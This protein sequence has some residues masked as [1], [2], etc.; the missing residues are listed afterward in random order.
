MDS[1]MEGTKENGMSRSS[2]WVQ[3]RRRGCACA[4]LLAA[5]TWAPGA[6]A[7]EDA[8]PAD[9][10]AAAGSAAE[11]GQNPERI[12]GRVV[13]LRGTVYAQTPG[14]AR[15]RLTENAPIYP[16]DRII[17]ARGAQ[18]GVLSGDYYTGLD[19]DTTLTYQKRGQSAP[20]V[21]LERGDVRVINAGEGDN[22]RIA[23][24][25]MVARAG[26][27][28][29]S[30]TAVQEKAWIV[31]IVCALEGQVT[32]ADDAGGSLVVEEGGC[33]ASKPV[34]GL[35][36]AGPA[37]ADSG[38]AAPPPVGAAGA[39]KPGPTALAN[40]GPAPPPPPIAGDAA[41]RFPTPDVGAPGPFLAALGAAPPI[42]AASNPLSLIQP[43]DSPASGCGVSV[44]GGG[45]GGGGGFPPVNGWVGGNLPP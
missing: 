23:T 24:P 22:A 36:L 8:G 3:A 37:P 11:R 7:T 5:L 16:G 29:A 2:A 39:G 43:C 30:A 44:A 32:V 27:P 42:S 25:G 9:P 33:A 6:L 34:E 28:D 19:E 31:S 1:I 45:G 26:A 18:L 4:A 40:A 10:W 38:V 20:T 41:K 35:F 14:E 12:I 15:R 13:G 17:T 21:T